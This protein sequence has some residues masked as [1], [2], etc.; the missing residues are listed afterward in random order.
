MVGLS[1]YAERDTW[2]HRLHPEVKIAGALLL[3]V[4]FM[5][6][7]D[8]RYLGVTFGLSLSLASWA[9]GHRLMLR[10]WRFLALLVIMSTALWAVFLD[11]KAAR[12]M[13]PTWNLLGATVTRGTLLYGLAMGLRITGMVLGGLA[14]IASTRPE[15]F[16]YGLRSLGLPAGLSSAIALSFFLLPM[17]VATAFTVRQ[18]QEA[19]G[20]E[21]RRVGLGGRFVRSA[22][23]VGPVL[24]YSLRRADDLTRALEI[25]GMG[26]R[27]PTYARQRPV[28]TKETALLVVAGAAA[29]VCVA[30]RLLAGYGAILPRL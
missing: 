13:L 4:V 21:L 7:N 20:L 5:A 12:D 8:P 29:L 15:E 22:A 17:L 6:F 16:S 28:K 18:A 14:L 30:A 10:T 1:L 2:L 9:G 27:P 3:F 11:D 25:W 23:V 19:R 24:G 26:T